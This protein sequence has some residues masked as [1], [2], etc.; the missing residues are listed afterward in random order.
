MSSPELERLALPRDPARRA[1]T[2]LVML[3]GA[4]D[5]PQ[6]FLEHGLATDCAAAGL[7][8]DLSLLRTDLAAVAD[9]RLVPALH[10]QVIAPARE[11]GYR[12][13]I[14]GGISIGAM[15]ALLHQDA[16]PGSADELLT[17]ATYPGNRSLS[18]HVAAAG[19][20]AR[21]DASTLANDEGEL[22]AWRAVQGLGRAGAPPLW[23]GYG[24]D[25]RFAASQA[26]MAAALPPS[27]V[28]TAAGGHD[29]PTWAC[30]WRAWLTA[31]RET[32]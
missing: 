23:F 26:M 32:A 18:A 20:I 10:D 14:L 1:P 12:H 8:A 7:D 28:L 24:E 4:Y 21:W 29:W 5:A 13:L 9:G 3:A 16:F 31:R 19:G 6:Q 17:L 25:D 15:M 27:R 22:R 30:L 11:A 2:L